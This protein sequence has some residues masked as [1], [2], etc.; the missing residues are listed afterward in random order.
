MDQIDVTLTPNGHGAQPYF[1]RDFLRDSACPL[2]QGD[3]CTARLVPN[4]G[5]LL[6]PGHDTD[7]YRVQPTS[8]GSTG[9]ESNGL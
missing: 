6:T 8:S 2:S 7:E 5:I 1:S 3:E 9:G 4:I